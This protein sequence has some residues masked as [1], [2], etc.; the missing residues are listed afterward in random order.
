MA[1]APVQ[2]D[3]TNRKPVEWASDKQRW[4]FE[5]GP[6]PTLLLGGVNSAKTY[7]ACLKVLHLGFMYPHSHIAIV[8]KTYKQLTKTTMQTFYAM[9][10][11]AHYQ[12][13]TRNDNDGYLRLNN[14]TEIFFIHL[15]TPNSLTL[16]QGLELNAAFVDQAE[17]ISGQAWE[18]L[19]TRVGRWSYAEVP[20]W[21]IAHHENETGTSWPWTTKD[22][23]PMPPPYLFAT[24]NP[25]GD[26]LHW[27]WEHFSEES[28]QWQKKWRALG[29]QYEKT[30]TRENRYALQQNIDTLLARDD[31]WIDRFVRGNWGRPEGCIF[32]VDPLSI[33][34]PDQ[35]FLSMIKS[36]MRLGRA[37]DHGDN[38]PTCCLLGAA[39]GEGN[40][41]IWAEYYQAGVDKAGNEHNIADHRKAISKM[42]EGL[43]FQISVADPQIF[44]K[45]RNI[46]GYSTRSQR[47][48]IADEY[49][50]R[51]LMDPNTALS[52]SQADNNEDVSRS[53][54]REYLRVDPK[55]KHPITGQ[56][57]APRLYFIMRSDE[58]PQGCDRVTVELK[59]AKRIQIGESNG[60]A[61]FSDERDPTI[62]DH[63]LDALRYYVGAHP[64]PVPAQPLPNKPM[65]QM[66]D[67][68]R[69][70]MVVPPIQRMPSAPPTD[71]PRR[72]WRSRAGGY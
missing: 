55:H 45:S 15:D 66:I 1:T 65:I 17:E 42:C 33:I 70:M 18:I 69:V 51:R 32:R 44:F 62:S 7:G 57:G 28:E 27:L 37:L 47:W 3:E 52:F 29:Y 40:L 72:T 36:E 38:A 53:R 58:Y 61:I 21:V 24:A 30:D 2:R 59:A 19:E 67:S 11:P 48:S 10:D 64:M 5:S 63:A 8:R 6:Q 13:G 25:P 12:H 43:R 26:E 14:G 68:G 22:G 4:L 31:Q 71:R 54:L 20:P 39:D 46:S 9:L 23:K 56:M 16:L 35:H 50:D 60:R 41:Y 49:M 34:E